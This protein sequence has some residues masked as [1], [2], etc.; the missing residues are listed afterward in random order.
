M[1]FLGPTN[2]LGMMHLNPIKLNNITCCQLNRILT[3]RIK[4]EILTTVVE[5]DRAK[6][7]KFRHGKPWLCCATR[8][9]L[10]P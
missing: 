5:L 10:L 4:V 2:N 3:L 6:N 9:V 7:L 8:Y 1:S